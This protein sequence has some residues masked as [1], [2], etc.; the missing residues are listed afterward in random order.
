MKLQNFVLA[1]FLTL[2]APTTIACASTPAAKPAEPETK[3]VCIQTTDAKTQKPKE[4]CKTIKVHQK[5]EGT[6][7]PPK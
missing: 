6:K 2:L 7:V 1:A 5:L 3:R 4:V